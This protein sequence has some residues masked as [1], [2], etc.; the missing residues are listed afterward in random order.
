MGAL[1]NKI[2]NLRR[3]LGLNQTALAE[4]LGVTQAS[5]SRWEKGSVP[6][7]PRLSQLADLAGVS[8]RE[9][10]SS[11]ESGAE[12]LLGRYFVRGEVAA[13]VWTVAYEWPENDWLPYSGGSHIEAPQGKRF[14]LVAKG[15]SMN[16]IYP[17]GT[18]LDCVAIDVFN[19]ELVSGQRVIVE[20]VRTDGE[21][22]ATVKEYAVADD[23]REWLLPRSSNPAFQAP[24]AMDDPGPD[25]QE[26]RIVAVVVGSY[27]AEPV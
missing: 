10:I 19:G 23:G 18:V 9:F 7:G 16:L 27:R 22:E 13:G 11:A 12:P 25:I 3:S 15:E 1:A 17:E 5:V 14:G 2:R 20:R 26:I 8:V 6:D 24:I 4:R 21:I